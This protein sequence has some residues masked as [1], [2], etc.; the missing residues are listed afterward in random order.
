MHNSHIKEG[1]LFYEKLIGM[2]KLNFMRYVH[3]K[4]PVLDFQ[5]VCH[6]VLARS[7]KTLD[8]FLTVQ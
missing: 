8:N 1:E 2:E 3:V 6:E 7:Q 5:T 4:K